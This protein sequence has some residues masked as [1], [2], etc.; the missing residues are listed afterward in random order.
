MATGVEDGNHANH[1]RFDSEIHGVGETS[2]SSP[3]NSPFQTLVT[4]WTGDDTAIC[5][6]DLFQKLRAE[7]H[8]FVLR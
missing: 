6:T 5:R 2:E 3:S 1:V 4:E 8:S 7:P